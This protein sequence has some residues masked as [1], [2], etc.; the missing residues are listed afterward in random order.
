M[1]ATRRFKF[2][3]LTVLMFL[4]FAFAVYAGG[5]KDAGETDGAR[6]IDNGAKNIDG[7]AVPKAVPVK[8]K[9]IL[10]TTTS[11]QDSGLLGYLLPV[12][13]RET[14]W[15]VDTIAVGTGAA[16]KMGRD[17]EADVLLVHAKADEV[18]FVADGF[19]VKRY[20]VMYNDFII[21]GPESPIAYN[22]DVQQTFK[23]I[24]NRNLPFVS[25][26]DDSGTHKME[27]TIWKSAGVDAATLGKYTSAGQ[28]MGATLQIADELKAYTL[29]DRATWLTQKNSSLKIVCEK[30]P[31]LLNYYGVIAVSPGI[32]SRIN[33]E[34]GQAF[35]D[36][37]LKD[38][39]QQLI[40]QYGLAEY[41]GALFTPNAGANK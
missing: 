41:G 4:V 32:N 11:T 40:G 39:T 25:R 12:F 29:S 8:G 18:K 21:V 1:K 2:A 30:S 7:G 17:G 36:W 33:A 14:G 27:L 35:A 22:G 38:S 23:A 16:L 19:G 34:G 37:L 24:A 28:G 3:A 5:K 26:G 13:T 31:D 10:S 20:D 6:G 15:E 9:I